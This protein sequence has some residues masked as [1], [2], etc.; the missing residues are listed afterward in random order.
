MLFF[1]R[2]HFLNKHKVHV[3]LP[4]NLVQWLQRIRA[5]PHCPLHSESE[6]PPLDQAGGGYKSMITSHHADGDIEAEL[7]EKID[8]FQ[9]VVDD[10]FKEKKHRSLHAEDAKQMGEDQSKCRPI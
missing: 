6:A 5:P 4:K 7:V 8:E 10:A 2:A 3:P 9:K 1:M